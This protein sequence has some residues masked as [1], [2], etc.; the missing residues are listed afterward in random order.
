MLIIT[1]ATFASE[2]GGIDL[3]VPGIYND[4]QATKKLEEINE[5]IHGNGSFSSVQLWYLGR[6]LMLKI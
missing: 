5:A 3:H 4:V 6:L 2:R 1:E